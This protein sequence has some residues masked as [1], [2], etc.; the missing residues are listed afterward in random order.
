MNIH[1]LI[2]CLSWLSIAGPAFAGGSRCDLHE[3]N[4]SRELHRF[5]SLRA[6]DVV[7]Q[8]ENSGGGLAALVD[9]TAM[10]NLGAGDVG[11]PLG[12]GIDGARALARTMQ[13]DSYRFLGW[14]SMDMEPNACSEREVEVEVEFIDSQGKRVSSVKFTFEVEHVRLVSAVGWERSFEAGQL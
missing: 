1:R 11:R 13:A 5:L 10:F 12:T 3:F 4:S 2:L 9:P 6:V 14:D 8:A 7:R